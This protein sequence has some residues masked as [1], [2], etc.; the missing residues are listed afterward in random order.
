MRERGI[1]AT[2]GCSERITRRDRAICSSV[3]GVAMDERDTSPGAG[4]VAGSVDTS[5]RRAVGDGAPGQRLRSG[6][7]MTGDAEKVERLSLQARA[8]LVTIETMRRVVEELIDERDALA[9]K[10]AEM[11]RS[12]R[13]GCEE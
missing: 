2:A 10:L 12:N 11:E 3:D 9:A 5:W 7:F 1:D 8:Y 13:G 4:L 6:Q